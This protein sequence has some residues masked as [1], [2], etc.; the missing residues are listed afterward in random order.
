MS[1]VSH[2]GGDGGRDHLVIEFKGRLDE[3]SIISKSKMFG[4]I[5]SFR[6]CEEIL[7][8]LNFKVS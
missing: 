5:N 3:V 2:V 4:D 6:L 8:S 7:I 1:G